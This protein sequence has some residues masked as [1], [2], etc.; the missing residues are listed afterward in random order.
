MVYGAS[1]APASCG[2]GASRSPTRPIKH[3]E[4]LN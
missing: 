1:S 2:R 3:R 4:Q